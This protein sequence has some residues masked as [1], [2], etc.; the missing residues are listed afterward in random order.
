MRR[1]VALFVLALS[2]PAW[3]ATYQVGPSREHRQLAE[4][5]KKLEPGDVIELDGDASY[6]GGVVFARPGKPQAKITVRGVRVNGKRPLLRGGKN[7]LEARGDH[8]VFEGLELTEG[9]FRCF[10]HHAH[11]VTLRDSVVHDCPKHGVL[12]ADEGSGSLLLEWVE[13]YRSGGG[14]RDHQIYVTTDQKA[15]PKSVFRMQHSYVH[16]A[17]GGNNVKSRAERNE[18]FYNWIEGATYHELELIGPDGQ[19]EALA[20]EDSDVVG[21]VLVKTNE[22]FVVRFGGDGTGQTFGRYR[23]FNNTVIT[24]AGASAVFRLFDGIESVEARN[25]VFVAAGGGPVSLVRAREAKWKDGQES[26]AGSNNWYPTGSTGVPAGWTASLTGADPGL[27][28]GPTD[29][30]PARGSPLV[31]RGVEN[32]LVPSHHP[33]LRGLSA[34]GQAEARRIT[35]AVDLGAFELAVDAP[36]AP[37][38]TAAP[39]GPAPSACGCRSGPAGPS[40]GW[41]A[42]FVSGFCAL[43]AR[44]RRFR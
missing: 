28:A 31:D 2:S 9:S 32:G 18:I 41:I 10:Y 29:P 3:S 37:A 16:D 19:D 8:Y 22:S 43:V 6:E 36:V 20:R 11:D 23:F 27:R 40:F 25:N 34:P 1:T 14:T 17:N 38:P 21:N 39:K 4:V 24:R 30:R 7:T 13:V 33:P 26:F 12:G 35:S 15:H 5:A 42:L 44:A